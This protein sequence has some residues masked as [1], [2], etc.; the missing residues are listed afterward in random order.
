MIKE[1]MRLS[2]IIP[3]YNVEEYIKI[4]IDSVINQT[5]KDLEIILVDDESPDATGEIMDQYEKLYDNIKVIHQSNGGLSA[6]RNT[7]IKAATGEFIAFVDSDDVLP[8]DSYRLLMESVRETGS[9]LAVG[10]VERFDSTRRIPSPMHMRA[11]HDTIQKTSIEEH[12]ELVYD[13]TSWNKIY[14]TRIFIDNK[15][16]YPVGLLYEDIPVSMAFHLLAKKVDIIKDVVYGWRRREG[17]NRSIT[18]NRGNNIQHYK[19]RLE[20]L[21]LTRSY[22]DKYGATKNVEDAFNLKIMEND[23]PLSM[24]DIR[25]SDED[26]ILEFQKIT[27]LFIR[28][29]NNAIFKKLSIKN[30]IQYSALLQGNFEDLKKYSY[31][32]RNIGRIVEKNNNFQYADSNISLKV[33]QSVDVTQSQK[34]KQK[35]SEVRFDE[36]SKNAIITGNLQLDQI[37]VTKRLGEKLSANLINIITG[38]TIPIKIVR[39]VV[40]ERRHFL[41]HHNYSYFKITFNQ[42]EAYEVLGIGIWKIKIN[43]KVKNIN[44][45]DF[46]ANPKRNFEKNIFVGD[47]YQVETDFSFNNVLAFNA[48][49]VRLGERKEEFSPIKNLIDNIKMQDNS[50]VVSTWVNEPNDSMIK[51]V[52]AGGDDVLDTFAVQKQITS[53]HR[54]MFKCSFD[55][56]NIEND[57]GQLSVY[58]VDQSGLRLSYEFAY[59]AE[60]IEY[61]TDKYSVLVQKNNTD[62]IKLFVAN[63]FSKLIALNWENKD[64][65]QLKIENELIRDEIENINLQLID[66]YGQYKYQFSQATVNKNNQINIDL[67]LSNKEKNSYIKPAVYDIFVEFMIDDKKIQSQVR[68]DTEKIKRITNSNNLNSSFNIDKNNFLILNQL[69][70]WEKQDN[71][72]FKRAINFSIYYPL[73]RL[74]PL[75]KKTIIFDSYWG[76][77]FN[78]NEKAIYDYI[79]EY[80]PEYECVWLFK[81]P[82]TAITGKGKRVR[83]FSKKYWYYMARAKYIVENTNL[84]NQYAKRKGQIE[85]QSLHGTFMKTMGFDEPFFKEGSLTRQNNFANRIE[86]WD[87]LVS[88]SPYMDVTASRAFDFHKELIQSGFPRNDIL[89]TK[90]DEKE[91]TIIK[92]SLGLSTDKKIILYAPTFRDKDRFNLELDIKQMQDKLGDEYILLVRLH[93]FVANKIDLTKLDG[94]AYDVSKYPN[95]E[96]LYLISDVLITDYSSVMFDYAHLKRPMIFFAYDLNNYVEEDRGVYLDYKD[97]VP[98]PIVSNTNQIIDE[99]LDFPYLEKS[100]T[101]ALIKFYD[102]FCTYGRNGDAAKQVFEKMISDSPLHQAQSVKL[103]RN[104]ISKLLKLNKFYP[105]IFNVIGKHFNKKNIIIF[106]SFSGRKYSDSPKYVYEY[107]KDSFSKYKMYWIIDKDKISYFKENNIPYIIRFSFRGIFKKARAKVWFTNERMPLW[108]KKPVGMKVIQTWHGTP[109]KTIGA[110]LDVRAMHGISVYRHLKEVTGDSDRWDYAVSPN[111]YSSD[112]F[113]HAFRLKRY[114]M[115]NSGSPK[116]DILTNYANVETDNIKA[117]FGIDLNKRV[118]LYAPTWRDNE[119]I[120]GDYYTARLHLDLNEMRTELGDDVVVLIRTHHLIASTLDLTNYESFAM[121]V[122]DYEDINDLYLISDLLITDYSSVF[123]DFSILKRPIIF[124]AYDLEEYNKNI[125]GLYFDYK[126]EVPGPIVRDTSAVITEINRAFSSEQLHHNYDQ[127]VEKYNSWDD[128]HATERLVDFVMNNHTYEKNEVLVDETIREIRDGATVWSEVYGSEGYQFVG[129]IDARINNQGRVD[130]TGFLVDPIQKN[131]IEPMFMHI[132]MSDGIT[133]WVEEKEVIKKGL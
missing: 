40:N 91:I 16:Q 68:V 56:L 130:K 49:Q 31:R 2:V 5:Y 105:K 41:K 82:N 93:Y 12:P 6:A 11:I 126:K 26:Y 84:P 69:L 78:G 120:K 15:L 110:D 115:I 44:V 109:L 102:K 125:R 70:S 43:Y 47:G 65:I 81:D 62:K 106:E 1:R 38:K 123:F 74:L 10:A 121:D 52:D 34:Y 64:T 14:R 100:Y 86:R 67:N 114:Q 20:V 72:K 8:P 85:V 28:D 80:R 101:S 119:Y 77:Y 19:D 112:I 35:I 71:S 117:N 127:F 98:G 97:T 17:N 36:E 63:Y 42:Q 116:N 76:A 113:K 95:V 132:T 39:E 13:T 22:M 124:F 50:L 118:I 30:Q 59:A 94:F 103:I 57:T 46:L 54:V 23:I 89:Y 96:N 92:K 29:I 27:A 61:V 108:W 32:R 122:S 18:Q 129:N 4:C 51:I 99:L 53:D 45:T 9:D 83:Y 111:R 107:M 73:V 37:E 88:P 33:A 48:K 21:K 75:K 3:G 128:G 87:Y 66:K 90:N 131:I 24:Q 60:T 133:G 79:Q 7:G 55:N 25:E 104:K 58:L